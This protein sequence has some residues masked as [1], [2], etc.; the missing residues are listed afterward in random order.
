[1]TNRAAML[2]TPGIATARAL[3]ATLKT[4]RADTHIMVQEK[5]ACGRRI[6]MGLLIM[7]LEVRVPPIPHACC[8]HPCERKRCHERSCSSTFLLPWRSKKSGGL[9]SKALLA[10]PTGMA[11]GK[12]VPR[13]AGPLNRRALTVEGLEA[14]QPRCT[15]LHHGRPV[16]VTPGTTC[17]RRHQT[18]RHA[19]TNAKFFES[20]SRRT[21]GLLS[22]GDGK[23]VTSLIGVLGPLSTGPRRGMLV[24]CHMQSLVQHSPASYGSSSGPTPA[25]SN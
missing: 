13:G 25:C 1:M 21:P 20:A 2:R 12:Q 23:H 6:E 8:Y 22:S 18:H 10:M 19:V 9:L 24:T 5:R 4:R 7:S 11:T 14:P 15:P 16:E 3:N 17:P